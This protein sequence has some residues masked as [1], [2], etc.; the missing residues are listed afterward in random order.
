MYGVPDLPATSLAAAAVGA[1]SLSSSAAVAATTP[2]PPPTPR[3]HHAEAAAPGHRAPTLLD[4]REMPVMVAADGA[5]GAA[6]GGSQRQLL[7]MLHTACW[8]SAR[9]LDALAAAAT[10]QLHM[11]GFGAQSLGIV[12]WSLA[13]LGYSPRPGWLQPWLQ[14]TEQLV[15]DFRPANLASVLCALSAWGEVPAGGAAGALRAAAVRLLPSMG[16]RELQLTASALAQLCEVPPPPSPPPPPEAEA[17]GREKQPGAGGQ[18]WIRRSDGGRRT[19]GGQYGSRQMRGHSATGRSSSSGSSGGYVGLF[20]PLQVEG[21]STPSPAP[22]TS[23]QRRHRRV[24]A[25]V[26]KLL[27]QRAVQVSYSY[28]PRHMARMLRLL[29]LRL[30]CLRGLSE[31]RA[32]LDGHAVHLEGV[33]TAAERRRRRRRHRGSQLGNAVDVAALTSDGE[34]YGRGLPGIG[35]TD[36]FAVRP[37]RRELHELG[38]AA[39]DAVRAATPAG[40]TA[41]SDEAAAALLPVRWWRAYLA[42]LKISN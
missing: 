26:E 24:E 34:E 32:L 18:G 14:R 17:A 6:G 4:T 7:Q 42:A 20:V 12:L 8:P 11:A 30:G 5:G 2:W 40:S 10:A 3:P 39:L 16:P 37:R 31:L 23:H 29:A 21:A 22:S 15:W 28:N 41:M 1:A 13:G 36:G 25:R 19:E 33:V 27:V 38:L 9:W 35:G